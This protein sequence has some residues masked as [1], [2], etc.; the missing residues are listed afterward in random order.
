MKILNYPAL[1]AILVIVSCKSNKTQEKEGTVKDTTYIEIIEEKEEPP[2][3]PPPASILA[4]S[5]QMIYEDGS[6]SSFDV[7]ND[8]TKALWNVI[9]GSGDAE[10]PSEKTRVLLKGSAD[11]IYI[12]IKRGKYATIERKNVSIRDSLALIMDNTGCEELTVDVKRGKK[13]IYKGVIE[14]HCG[15]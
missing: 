15:E 10:Q 11:S 8:K 9:I 6:L 5:A 2:P 13:N 14:Y 7:L 3:P 1:I 12:V 4:V